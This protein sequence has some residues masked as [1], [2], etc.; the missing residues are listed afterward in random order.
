MQGLGGA[1][2]YGAYGQ[3]RGHSM[4]MAAAT[5]PAMT[6]PGMGLTQSPPLHGMDGLVPP[7]MQDIHAG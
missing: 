3:Y 4:M 1:D 5:H 6:H 7:H 2:M